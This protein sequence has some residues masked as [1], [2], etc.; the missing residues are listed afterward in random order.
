MTQYSKEYTED[1]LNKY[2]V[3]ES[4]EQDDYERFEKY[5]NM[6]YSKFEMFRYIRNNL[7]HN[8]SD[9]EFPIIVSKSV[10]DDITDILKMMNERIT[11]RAVMKSKIY[12][13]TLHSKLKD[14]ISVVCEKNYSYVPILDDEGLV[15]GVF[16][17]N[18]LLHYIHQNKEG[19]IYDENTRMIEFNN[20]LIIDDNKNEIFKF[21]SKDRYV[22]ETEKL[23]S[24]IDANGKR[25]GSLFVT[26]DGLQT[27]KI[28]AMVS[29][30]DII[31]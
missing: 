4:I 6:Y 3:M 14:V 27:Q 25:L 11:E 26:N 10:L 19:I 22:Y 12:F 7:T 21:V 16:S 2:K 23:F 20:L 1:F 24:E 31:K 5:K 28:L 29:S 15:I 9:G 8:I 13:A 17:D 18:T 30:W